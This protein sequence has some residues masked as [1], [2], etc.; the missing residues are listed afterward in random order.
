MGDFLGLD[1]LEIPGQD[2]LFTLYREPA[3]PK[4]IAWLEALVGR[5]VPAAERV[6]I[7]PAWV[8]T[9]M[10]GLTL[11]AAAAV[12][13]TTVPLIVRL[14]PVRRTRLTTPAVALAIAGAV[15][16]VMAWG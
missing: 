12:L 13:A 9:V 8:A 5:V 1:R 11:A 4:P 16:A 10:S 6:G 2:L 3:V 14:L 15:L 7:V